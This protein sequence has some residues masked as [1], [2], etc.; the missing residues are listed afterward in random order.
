MKNIKRF[1]VATLLIGV[2]SMSTILCACNTDDTP[3]CSLA[4]T[5]FYLKDQKSL[6]FRLF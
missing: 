4:L 3:P 1:L 5:Q 6:H 2:L